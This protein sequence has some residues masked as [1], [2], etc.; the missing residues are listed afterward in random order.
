M[1]WKDRNI[2]DIGAVSSIRERPAYPYD[3]SAFVHEAFEH[4]VCEGRLQGCRILVAKRRSAIE[5]RKFVPV[6]IIDGMGPD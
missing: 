5:V 4:A 6:E 2:A 3:F 1:S